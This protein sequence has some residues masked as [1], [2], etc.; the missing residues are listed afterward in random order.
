M[1]TKKEEAI[2]KAKAKE[3]AVFSSI[4]TI[5]ENY[6]QDP[7]LMAELFA[8]G[9]K[10]Y[11]YSPRNTMLILNQNRGAEF[12]AS[13][14]GWKNLGYSVK[15]GEHGLNILVPVDVTY[16]RNGTGKD[17]WVQLRN[18]TPELKRQY[19][20][21][22]VESQ[23]MRFYKV[24][25]VFDI[26]QTNMPVEEYPKYFNMG[27]SSELHDDIAKGLISFSEDVLHCKV[28]TED[29]SSISLRGYYSQSDNHIS[30][31]DKLQSTQLLSTLSHELGHALIHNAPSDK[32]ASQKEF[33]ADALS[34]M[35][36][37]AYGVETTQ[38]RISH[39]SQHFRGFE[40]DILE[41]NLDKS[42]TDQQ[43]AVDL[44]MHESFGDVFQI[45]RDNIDVINE[46]VYQFVPK[47]QL[48][49]LT[50]T[51][52]IIPKV[53]HSQGKTFIQE[54]I[55]KAQA[56]QGNISHNMEQEVELEGDMQR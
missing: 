29:L 55:E 28:V 41:Q 37:S 23:K 19:E 10:F 12:V 42:A 51:Q 46:H 18:A 49:G 3:D 36:D 9:S 11:K 8:F 54:A 43:M 5:A 53:E 34:I 13:F 14:Q 39:L 24:G 1:R 2:M 26:A 25:T 21:G 40:N 31:N 16:L 56:E 47:E 7:A 52:K 45:F 17:D 6:R 44:A 33:E 27:I 48:Q 15:R 38:S 50:A 35:L 22:N 20:L 30:L 4:K 32:S